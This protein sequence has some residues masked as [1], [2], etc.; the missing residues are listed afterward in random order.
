MEVLPLK[1]KKEQKPSLMSTPTLT[2]IDQLTYEQALAEL[3]TI[4]MALENDKHSL[5]QAVGL[6]ERGQA[7]AQHCAALLEKAELKIQQLLGSELLP[8]AVQE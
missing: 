7:L 2:P 3:E 4:V 1:S 6:F 8:F 5:E